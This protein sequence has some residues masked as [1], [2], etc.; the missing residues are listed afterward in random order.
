MSKITKQEAEEL[1]AHLLELELDLIH[2]DV[3]E[4]FEW[5]GWIE[6]FGDNSHLLVDQLTSDSNNEFNSQAIEVISELLIEAFANDEFERDEDGLY[7]YNMPTIYG[8]EI[9]DSFEKQLAM[10][11]GVGIQLEIF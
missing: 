3:K 6:K 1:A 7:N 5:N 4:H 11:S 9:V 2:N 10:I 8:G